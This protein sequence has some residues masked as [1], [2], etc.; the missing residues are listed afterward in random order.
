[1][2]AGSL[3]IMTDAAHLLSDVAAFMISLFAVWLAEHPPTKT[4]TF[5]FHRVEAIG[6]LLS[7]ILI[8]A[9]TGVLVY[10]AVLRI[11]KPEPVDG[12]IMFIVA[13]CGLAVNL[14]MMKVG[15]EGL[16]L[17][18]S[19]PRCPLRACRSLHSPDPPLWRGARPLA[20]R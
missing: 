15:E 6:A 20:R 17:R 9:L 8:W 13:C 12:K 18:P 1:L 14:G 7:V 16:W 4:H 5:G 10:E 19:P 2:Q 3:A 11:I